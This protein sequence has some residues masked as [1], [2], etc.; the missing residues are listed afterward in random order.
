[1]EPDENFVQKENEKEKEFLK[2]IVL[3]DSLKEKIVLDSLKMKKLHE[4]KSDVSCLPTLK[5]S[6]IQRELPEKL[7]LVNKGEIFYN[8]QITNEINS[9]R[10]QNLI[11]MDIPKLLLPYL[12]LFTE[13]LT[14]VGTNKWNHLELTEHIEMNTG[15]V[16]AS[17]SILPNLTE[18]DNYKMMLNI[19]SHCLQ[20]NTN[21]MLE[22]I[23]EIFNNP[24]FLNDLDYLKSL[25]DQI[26]IS[27]S[28]SIMRSGSKY[29]RINASS[30]ISHSSLMEET[31]E[32]ISSVHFINNVSSNENIEEIAEKLKEIANLLLKKNNTR[33]LLT[34][35]LSQSE[36][37][38]K[39]VDEI[40]LNSLVSPSS[41][42]TNLPAFT[43]K[44]TKNF[45]GIPSQ[46]NFCGQTQTALPFL[47]DDFPV[48]NVSFSFDLIG[49]VDF[50]NYIFQLFTHRNP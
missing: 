49:L 33:I 7:N 4:E 11:P 42:N 32:G 24:N 21:K 9:I 43:P 47:S 17:I 46:V 29:A 28:N 22:I 39:S 16:S 8:E 6:D 40:F 2:Q 45:I 19:N 23:S 10:I 14:K 20:K 31:F 1:M 13:V 41:I 50:K 37:F 5:I 3:T 35:E 26:S 18:L 48:V 27:E 12:P 44:N 25:I 34:A 15:G 30:S 36:T 38:S